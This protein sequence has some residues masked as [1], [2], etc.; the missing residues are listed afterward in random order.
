I[1]QTSVVVLNLALIAGIMAPSFDRQ[2]APHLAEARDSTFYGLPLVHAV[3]GTLAE[4]LGV[5]ILLSAGTSW[6]PVSVRIRDFKA[7]MRTTMALWWTVIVLGVGIY[8]VWYRSQTG[9][10][11]PTMAASPPAVAAIEVHNFA[12]EPATLTIKAGTTVEWSDSLGR[13]T[14]QFD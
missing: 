5:Y 9:A 4:L 2:V 3:L 12:F 13:H 8:D 14:V 6:L 1:C 10:A 11:A 7:W